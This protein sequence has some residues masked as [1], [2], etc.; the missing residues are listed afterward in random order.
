MKTETTKIAL[1]GGSFDPPHFAHIDI[2]VNL[3]KRF[4]RVIVMPSY[5]SPFKSETDNAA[6]RYK[7]CKKVFEPLGAE[8]SRYEIGKKSVSYTVDTAAYLARKTGG[9][10]YCVIGSEE[11]VRLSEW[12]DIDRLKTI[13]K[14]YV[15]TRPGFEPQK[16]LLAALKK[17]KIIVKRAP[18]CGVDNSS[19]QIKIDRAFGMTNKF[20]PDAVRAFAEKYGLFDPYSKY[21]RALSRYG[22]HYERLMHTYRTALR[23][24]E[25]AKMYGASVDD[26]LVACLLHD[27]AKGVNTSDYTD[28]VD[29][30]DFPLPT[31]HGP[32]GA[33]IAKKEFGVSEEIADAIT[34]HS[35]AKANMSVL[36]EIVYLADKT[37]NGRH[38]PSLEHKRYL[39][40]VDKNIAMLAALRE[41]SDLEGTE[42]CKFTR[43]AIEY[44]EKVCGD[45]TIPEL[46]KKEIASPPKKV[47]NAVKQVHN[48]ISERRF[49]SGGNGVSDIAF[50]AA[51][52]LSLHKARNIDIIDIDGKTIIADYFVIASVTS[53]TAVKAMMGYVED[54]LKKQFGIDPSKRDVNSEWT[55]LDFGG[56]IIHIF[57][58]KMRVFYNIE[59]LWSDGH[60][61]KRY[62]D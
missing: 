39:C 62:E 52:E 14:F 60:N 56:V 53:T 23:G 47:R 36:G 2:V 29:V 49:T 25:L 15:V 50:A 13:V 57:T 18:F 37:E 28:R 41:I 59:R 58:D 27:I 24:A 26:A 4:D 11:L 5:I 19:S 40:S 7:I 9:E 32:I 55:A 34:Y 44:Y 35:T 3:V 8:V 61:V 48:D 45:A 12:H 10:L 54:R 46:P 43:E 31:V 22:L 6:F 51:E 16:E 30:S 33:Y 1:F 42:A 20:V 38:Y 17:R 21:V